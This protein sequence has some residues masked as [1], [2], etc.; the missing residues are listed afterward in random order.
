MR[1][2]AAQLRP[3]ANPLLTNMLIAYMNDDADFIARR[4]A[5]VVGVA[6]E[7]GTYAT[8]EQKHWFA[9]KLE[10]RAYGDTYARGG[11]TFG[12]DTYKTLQWGLEHVIPV[13]HQRTSQIPLRLESVGLEWLAHQSNLRKEIAFAGDFMTT[14][15]WTT[16][17]T[18]TDWDDASGVPVTDSRTQRRVVRQLIGK[19]PNAIAMGEI[20]YDALCVNAEVKTLIQYTETQTV[21]RVE[22]LLAT[23]LGFEYMFVSR[24]VY[25]SANTG[26]TASI[27]PIMDDDALMFILEPGADMMSVSSMK[28]FGW[29]SGEGEVNTYTDPSTR[30]ST[31]LQH[32]EQWD[33]K[34][35]SADSGVFF[36]DIV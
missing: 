7:S 5:P 14:G 1:P 36:A 11:Y 18:P 31:V 12:S 10:R 15:V 32:T 22:S 25:N 6:E 13:E 24:A 9:D 29:D 35:V 2:T 28:T 19:A 4:C 21:E 23:V 8:I 34:L 33:Q 27:D 30:N 26:Q 16:N 20:V 17:P 3:I